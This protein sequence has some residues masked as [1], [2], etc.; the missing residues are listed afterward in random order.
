MDV[1]SSIK[2]IWLQSVVV[3]PACS[4]LQQSSN[5]G[6]RRNNADLA[7]DKLKAHGAVFA[8]QAVFAMWY[9]VGHIG[10]I[11]GELGGIPFKSNFPPSVKCMMLMLGSS[12]RQ[13]NTLF[14][15]S[16]VLSDNDPLSFALAREMLSAGALFVLAQQIEGGV[17]VKSKSDLLD[18]FLLVC[19]QCVWSR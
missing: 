11:Y 9:I 6:R 16:A 2:S 5:F 17:R 12:E 7:R 3:C 14:S 1:T 13:L 4:S 19:Y 18:I 15:C 8:V 10:V